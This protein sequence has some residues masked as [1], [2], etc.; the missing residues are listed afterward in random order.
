MRINRTIYKQTKQNKMKR[1]ERNK[2][3]AAI[4]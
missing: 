4:R 3:N 2:H 1:N